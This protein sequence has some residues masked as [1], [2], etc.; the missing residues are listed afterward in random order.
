MIIGKE[1]GGF[2]TESHRDLQ[3]LHQ[4]PELRQY[5]GGPDAVSGIDQRSLRLTQSR[6]DLFSRAPVIRFTLLRRHKARLIFRIDEGTLNIQRKIQP[7]RPAAAVSCQPDRLFDFKPHRSGIGD[8]LG[9]LGHRCGDRGGIH[10]LYPHLPYPVPVHKFT[11][12]GL[13][14]EYQ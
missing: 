8:T 7:Y 11:A 1:V 13:T 10:L 12:L 6:H 14:G 3:F 4:F 5:T 2:P 9:I